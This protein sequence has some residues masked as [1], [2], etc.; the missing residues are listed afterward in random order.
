[1]SSS[2]HG[3][4]GPSW[5]STSMSRPAC[6]AGGESWRRFASWA[7]FIAGNTK[8]SAERVSVFRNRDSLFF[9]GIACSIPTPE[10][11]ELP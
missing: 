9:T 1:M 4:C 8:R 6:S 10:D 2:P 5:D 11:R 3:G 7:E